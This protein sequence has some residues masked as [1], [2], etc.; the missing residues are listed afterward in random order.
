MHGLR[1]LSG[2]KG[3]LKVKV[4]LNRDVLSY[5]ITDNGVG[6]AFAKTIQKTQ[7]TSFGIDITRERIEHFNQNNRG[8]VTINDLVNEKGEPEGT[9]VKVLLPLN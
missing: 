3:E 9:E 7:H 1:H 6:R 4:G 5:L 8:S 2:K